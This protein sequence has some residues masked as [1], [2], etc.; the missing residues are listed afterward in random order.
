MLSDVYEAADSGKLTLLGLL[1]LSA[2]FDTVDHQILL[3]RLRHSF[4]I[5]G[6]VLDWIASYLTGRTQFVRFN[7]QSSK[8][9][10]VT[11]VVP[12]GLPFGSR[13][14]PLPRLHCRSRTRSWSGS[15][16]STFNV[17]A[18]ADDLQ[19]YDHTAPSG[20]AGLLQRM[21]ACIEDASI[22]TMPQSLEDRTHLVGIITTAPELYHGLRNERSGISHS[23]GRLGQRSRRLR[24]GLRHKLSKLQLRAPGYPKS[25]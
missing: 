5:F 12:Q 13:A 4:G 23:S 9:V 6:T 2:A 19:I 14:D 16:V 3:G 8:T 20:M 15:I 1:D 10:P 21:A 17:H 7:G 18:Y 24:A 22:W 25:P 11:S